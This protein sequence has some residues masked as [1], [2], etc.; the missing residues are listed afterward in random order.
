MYLV[1][2]LTYNKN[3]TSRELQQRLS[4]NLKDLRS[5][6][7][8]QET[9]A[10]AAGLSPQMINNIEGCR[11]WPSETTLVKLANA[12]D[13]DVQQFFSPSSNESLHTNGIYRE[14]SFV[15]VQKIRHTLNKTLDE[16]E[17]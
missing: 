15:V 17:F 13:V 16:L 5:G 4:Q 10:E 3:M 14:V 6:R 7:F 1:L 11:R 9:L 2:G 12:L 8:T